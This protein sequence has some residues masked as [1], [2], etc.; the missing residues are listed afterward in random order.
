[1]NRIREIENIIEHAFVLCHEAYIKAEHLPAYIYGITPVST[2]SLE[3]MEK[4]MIKQALARYPN[5][6]DAAAALGIDTSTLWRKLK[7]YNIE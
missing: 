4:N 3:E 1:M 2:L 5:K 7:K 6:K